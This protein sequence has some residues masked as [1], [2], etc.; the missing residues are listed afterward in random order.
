MLFL[1]QGMQQIWQFQKSIEDAFYY[2]M[3]GTTSEISNN[4]EKNVPKFVIHG[5]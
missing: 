3:E 1:K 4:Y 2:Q 5:S